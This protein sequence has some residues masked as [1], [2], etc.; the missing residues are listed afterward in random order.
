MC[1]RPSCHCTTNRSTRTSRCSRPAQYLHLAP[2]TP[3]PCHLQRPSAAS[4]KLKPPWQIRIAT[5][6]LRHFSS[7]PPEEK[8]SL[9]PPEVSSNENS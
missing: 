2:M 6:C 1:S 9:S 7:A 8:L 3:V 5:P 4:Y